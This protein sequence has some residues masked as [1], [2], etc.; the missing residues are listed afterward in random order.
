MRLA[1][2]ALLA[3]LTGCVVYQSPAPAPV[4]PPP[5]AYPPQAE[6][7]AAEA[8]P[9]E[10][11]APAPLGGLDGTFRISSRFYLEARGQ[12][13]KGTIDHIQA[14]LKTF[15]GSLMYRWTPNFT[16]GLGY[17]GYSADVTSLQRGSGGHYALTS[18]GPQ[19]FARVGF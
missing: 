14:S 1:L 17:L 15:N 6:A 19:L 8:P 11:S 18:K 16:L 7:P 2:Y 13:V 4:Q 10:E 9:P 3:A 12:Y 5:E